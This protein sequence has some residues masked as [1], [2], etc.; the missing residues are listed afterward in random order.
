MRR[1]LTYE[2]PLSRVY[3]EG[4]PMMQHDLNIHAVQGHALVFLAPHLASFD[5]EESQMLIRILS[6]PVWEYHDNEGYGED[7]EL[8]WALQRYG[9]LLFLLGRPPSDIFMHTL[10]SAF[11]SRTVSLQEKMI[12]IKR[13]CRYL[14]SIRQ[15]RQAIIE[16]FATLCTKVMHPRLITMSLSVLVDADSAKVASILYPVYYKYA[17]TIRLTPIS[18]ALLGEPT[19]ER[20]MSVPCSSTACL[21]G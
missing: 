11:F 2:R 13:V 15:T 12:L 6:D 14:I 4:H 17:I 19:W 10:Q 7:S 21:F 16:L 5:L 1:T 18:S 20:S 9:Q 8:G 3:T